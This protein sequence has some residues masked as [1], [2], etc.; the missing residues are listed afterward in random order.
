M[1]AALLIPTL[2]RPDDLAR[3]LSHVLP[4]LDARLGLVLVDDASTDPAHRVLLDGI[5]GHP[6]VRLV[7]LEARHGCTRA[8]KVVLETLDV[9]YVFMLDDDS[10]FTGAT[11]ADL[12]AVLDRFRAEPRLAAQAFPCYVPS[13]DASMD[14]VRAR[15]YDGRMVSGFIN[16]ACAVRMEAYHDIGGYR[17]EFDSPYGEE[18]DLCIRLMDRRW[19]IR[20]FL[21]PT[22]EHHQSVAA[23]DKQHNA[24]GNALNY[25]RFIWWYHPA[26]L[27][28][29]YTVS[30]FVKL[31]GNGLRHGQSISGALVGTADF[32]REAAHG[33]PHRRVR[34]E[35]LKVFYSLKRR[36]A[37]TAQEVNAIK[38][39]TWVRVFYEQ[40]VRPTKQKEE[41]EA[42]SP[43]WWRTDHASYPIAANEKT[44]STAAET[45]TER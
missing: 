13:R 8:R 44:L 1:D 25:F 14:A 3:T 32:V 6:H 22:V 41:D 4:L 7:R 34:S 31:L 21:E 36:T 39:H 24:R 11:R 2:D 10:Y 27:A 30:T 35:T 38:K 43:R 33:L 19:T 26:W 5:A 37:L 40:L 12:E 20:Q 28:L 15:V 18:R 9:P 17:A 45:Q 23:R 42:R 16:C 29:P